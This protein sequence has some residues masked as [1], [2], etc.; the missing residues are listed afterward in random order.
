MIASHRPWLP[1]T[2]LDDG[3]LETEISKIFSEW[4]NA[5]GNIEKSNNVSINWA[6]PAETMAP[7]YLHWHSNKFDF[8]LGFIPADGV[9]FGKS[10]LAYSGTVAARSADE[11]LLIDLS[12]KA[13]EDL[14]NRVFPHASETLEFEAVD[15]SPISEDNDYLILE[16]PSGNSEGFLT[17]YLCRDLAVDFRRSL[18][19]K[20]MS[21]KPI[22]SLSA[23]VEEQLIYLS[24]HIGSTALNAGDLN[25]L[26]SDDVLIFDSLVD[27][28]VQLTI[29][30][31]PI[32]ELTATL[33][34]ENE[35]IAITK[36]HLSGAT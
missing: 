30:G 34:A 23:A 7:S 31:R 21:S 33:T 18:A 27:Q 19:R 11:A 22:K 5:W 1:Q 24:A 12:K 26:K 32:S 10:L 29:N 15:Q 14:A 17:L 9:S 4:N 6:K 35:K 8:G 2:A 36:I 25:D 3:K 20:N 28:D 16:I 13:L